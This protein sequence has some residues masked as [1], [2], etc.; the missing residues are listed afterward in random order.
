VSQ[1]E[2]ADVHEGFLLAK[3][4]A[5]SSTDIVLGVDKDK[6]TGD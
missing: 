5:Q 4:L 2:Q 3:Q 6:T 1:V